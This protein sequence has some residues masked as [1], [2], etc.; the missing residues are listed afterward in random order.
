MALKSAP[1]LEEKDERLSAQLGSFGESL[2]LFLL[3]HR[4]SYRVAIVDHV[5]A[6][7]IA[8]PR[9]DGGK[10]YAISVKTRRFVTDDMSQEFDRKNQDHLRAFAKE[11]N[12]EPAVAWVL[13]DPP[14]E[15]RNVEFIDVYILTLNAFEKL[16]HSDGTKIGITLRGAKKDSLTISNA[17]CNQEALQNSE[18]V[19]AH[20]RLSL[21][22][23]NLD[24]DW[25]TTVRNN[26]G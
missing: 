11:F 15:S 10:A 2:T 26:K 5:G 4:W 24:Y 3:G 14:N 1:N 17:L 9:R 25:L 8:T 20:A 7:I 6:D 22:I 19:I 21:E 12:L 18:T 16:A 23:N 13:I